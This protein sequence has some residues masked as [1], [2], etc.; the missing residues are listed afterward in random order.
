MNN[1]DRVILKERGINMLFVLGGNGTQAGGNA[2]HNEN[3][4]EKKNAK[5][6]YGHITLGDISVHIEQQVHGAFAGYSGITVGICNTLYVYLPIP[7]I[8]YSRQVDPN[9]RMWHHY[10]TLICQPDL[11][12]R[13]IYSWGN[14]L[15]CP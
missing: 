11:I 5:G 9:S 10:L 7:E 15:K 6:P 4:F 2:I 1:N 14:L 3:W 12:T 8:S 13:F